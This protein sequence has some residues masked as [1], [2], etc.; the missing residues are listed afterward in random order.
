MTDDRKR[1]AAPRPEEGPSTLLPMLVGGLA[2]ITIG[3]IVIAFAV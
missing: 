2:L 1:A 3:M